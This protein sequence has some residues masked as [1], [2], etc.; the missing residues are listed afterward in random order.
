MVRAAEALN[1]EIGGENCSVSAGLAEA[2]TIK[3]G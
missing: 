2:R 3:Q 1:Y